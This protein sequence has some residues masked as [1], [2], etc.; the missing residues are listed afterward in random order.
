VARAPT[1][2]GEAAIEGA[3]GRYNRGDAD[4]GSSRIRI[5]NISAA[6]EAI[7]AAL[8]AG[9][10]G[11]EP[12]AD[13]KGERFVWPEAAV[14]EVLGAPCAA[15]WSKGRGRFLPA[16]VRTALRPSEDSTRL[17]SRRIAKLGG[18]TMSGGKS[19]PFS[20]SGFSAAAHGVT[21]RTEP[22]QADSISREKSDFWSIS[23]W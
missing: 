6:F 7:V 21:A 17:L 16:R 5:S 9:S 2:A 13:A 15:I 14:V 19:T 11:F 3:Q 12:E 18:R 23:I 22:S 10:V 8:R 4:V 1:G 20:R